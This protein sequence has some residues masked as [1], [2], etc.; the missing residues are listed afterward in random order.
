M[1]LK[2]TRIQL[3]ELKLIPGEQEVKIYILN[4]TRLYDFITKHT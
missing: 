2:T 1:I 4:S 3:K